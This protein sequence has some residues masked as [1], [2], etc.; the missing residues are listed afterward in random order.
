MATAAAA[1]ALPVRCLVVG[2]GPTGAACLG[3]LR[4]NSA[5]LAVDVW[6]KGRRPGGRMSTSVS[7]SSPSRR[8]DLGAQYL[9]NHDRTFAPW[10]AEMHSNGVLERAT[11]DIVGQ[12]KA[13]AE[14]PSYT[15]PGG[16]GSVVEA[17]LQ[18]ADV[19]AATR[20]VRL[21]AVAGDGGQ[22][23]AATAVEASGSEVCRN[24]DCVVLTLPVPQLL[25]LGG[26][27]GAALETSNI[28][29]AL[30]GVRYSSRFALSMWWEDSDAAVLL[31][32]VPWAGRYVSPDESASLRFISFEPRMHSSGESRPG[33][34][35]DCG[36]APRAPALVAHSSVSFGAERLEEDK[37][38]VCAELAAEVR[39]LIPALPDPCDVRPHKWRFSQVVTSAK[40]AAAAAAASGSGLET[41]DPAAAAWVVP[42]VPPLVLAGDAFA[43][44][45][46]EGCLRS[47]RAAAAAAV[48]AIRSASKRRC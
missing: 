14:L 20:L 9:T 42:G 18:G 7:R 45:N 26:S 17:M 25:A 12:H 21:E 29:S 41:L 22:Q 8:A 2:A 1:S 3:A 38:A 24:Y 34:G 37:E 46:I 32:A 36:T 31:D 6:D 10:F 15:A 16:M 5:E 40:D 33:E 30:Q 47:G 23:W 4:A 27:V 39:R 43:A 19:S 48:D 11:G 28:A 44:S 13:Q 35:G